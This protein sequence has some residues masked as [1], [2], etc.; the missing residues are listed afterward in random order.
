MLIVYV[1]SPSGH[2]PG[3]DT[4]AQREGEYE[5]VVNADD[6]DLLDKVRQGS[7]KGELMELVHIVLEEHFDVCETD[8]GS[9]P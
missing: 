9:F 7:E 2:L 3:D 6:P 1:A 8:T 4:T 5:L